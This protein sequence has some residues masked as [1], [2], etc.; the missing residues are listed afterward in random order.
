VFEVKGDEGDTGEDITV[1]TDGLHSVEGRVLAASDRHVPGLALVTVSMD[2]EVGGLVYA[3]RDGSFR[4]DYLP[5]GTYTV[6]TEAFD[7]EPEPG[8][9][10]ELRRYERTTA[11]VVVGE[12]DVVM[13]DL[14][15]VE[16]K[17][18]P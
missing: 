1:P 13:D 14:L 12:H 4:V 8:T 7:Y 15:V 6:R 3:S 18:K 9:P 16:A 2:D 11:T 10:R 17:P 5:K